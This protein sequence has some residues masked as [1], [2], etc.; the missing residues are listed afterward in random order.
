MQYACVW[1]KK[2]TR[3]RQNERNDE[4]KNVVD[5]LVFKMNFRQTISQMICVAFGHCIR[6]AHIVSLIRAI[7]QLV[8]F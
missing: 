5:A 3:G 8:M 7:D 1:H 4:K 6:Y 2:K